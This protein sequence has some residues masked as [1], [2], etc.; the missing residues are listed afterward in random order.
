MY[1]AE[2]RAKCRHVLDLHLLNGIPIPV[3]LITKATELGVIVDAEF[4]TKDVI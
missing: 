3:D 1:Q 2:Q 4:T